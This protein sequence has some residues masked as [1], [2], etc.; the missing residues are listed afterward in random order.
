MFINIRRYIRVIFFYK[1][2]CLNYLIINMK[3]I[4]LTLI[5]FLFWF[6]AKPE[7]QNDK[8]AKSSLLLPVKIINTERNVI[9][10]LKGIP[11]PLNSATITM[12]DSS[13]L[14]SLLVE[15]GDNVTVGD[16]LGSL[17]FIRKKNR[18][19]TPKDLRAPLSG[20]I[21][22]LNYQLDSP[23]SPYSVIMKIED[24]RQLKIKVKINRKQLN[25]IKPYAKAVFTINREEMEGYIR[26][27]DPITLQMEIIIPDKNMEYI[28]GESIS[29]YV[30]CGKLNGSFMSDRYFQGKDSLYVKIEE[31]IMIYIYKTAISD[32]LAL[33]YPSLFDKKEIFLYRENLTSVKNILY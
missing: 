3:N 19:Y 31:D 2:F 20:T 22:E 15:K 14:I 33:I 28:K 18:E 21:T 4:L 29:G 12:P 13:V 10:P 23:I 7:K 24:L 9:I 30:D 26:H 17:W 32:T 11:E 25:I 16:L 1:Y 6:C 27:I 8:A 5:L